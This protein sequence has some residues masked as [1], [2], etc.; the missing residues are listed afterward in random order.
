M[1]PV[2]LIQVDQEA[3]RTLKTLVNCAQ[4]SLDGLDTR[5]KKELEVIGVARAMSEKATNLI[6]ELL[7]RPDE[8]T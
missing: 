1:K 6:S 4:V 5:M 3:L 2:K 7:E 8:E